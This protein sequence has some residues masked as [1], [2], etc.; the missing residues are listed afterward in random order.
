[1]TSEKSLEVYQRLALNTV[2]YAYQEA[3]RRSISI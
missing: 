3:V 2:A 1:M